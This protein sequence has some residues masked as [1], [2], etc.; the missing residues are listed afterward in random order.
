LT[1]TIHDI[2]QEISESVYELDVSLDIPNG[3]EIHKEDFQEMVFQTSPEG[4]AELL[5][6]MADQVTHL[7]DLVSE[8][9]A[10]VDPTLDF[11]EDLYENVPQT[12]DRCNKT[13]SRKEIRNDEC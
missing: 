2:I 9:E 1:R 10:K 6:E 11:A 7:Q 5:T 13:L 8:I 12:C 4:I 3:G